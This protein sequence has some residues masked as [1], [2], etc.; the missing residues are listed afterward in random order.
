MGSKSETNL[1]I[2]VV[3]FSTRIVNIFNSPKVEIVTEAG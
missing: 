3:F 1:Q 2:F